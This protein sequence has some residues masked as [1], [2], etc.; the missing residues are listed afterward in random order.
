MKLRV[1]KDRSGVLDR[2]WHVQN[3]RGVT[4]ASFR[5]WE[6]AIRFALRTVGLA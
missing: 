5:D 2:A 1:L 6:T 4:M 3:L